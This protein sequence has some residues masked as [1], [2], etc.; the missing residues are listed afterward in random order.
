M[1]QPVPQQIAALAYPI[2]N[3]EKKLL[4]LSEGIVQPVLIKP[5]VHAKVVIILTG[6]AVCLL[7]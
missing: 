1:V 7:K 3:Q 5:R 4:I 2:V 6:V